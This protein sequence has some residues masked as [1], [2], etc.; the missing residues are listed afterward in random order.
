M[1][2][3]LRYGYGASSDYGRY[4]VCYAGRHRHTPSVDPREDQQLVQRF[5]ETT[6]IGPAASR[7]VGETHHLAGGTMVDFTH[8]TVGMT[9]LESQH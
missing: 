2:I 7:R 9:F 3:F 6:P 5:P 4:G 8:P 1:E